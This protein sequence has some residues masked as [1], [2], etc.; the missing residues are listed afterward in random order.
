[1]YSELATPEYT[2]LSA[3]ADYHIGLG[4]DSELKL[5]IRGDN[6]LDEEVRTHSSL[7]K[8]FSPEPG[9]AI[10]LGLRFEL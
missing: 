4:R 10:S 7:L 3:Y 2:L 6:L 5:F 9:R 8:D 1:M